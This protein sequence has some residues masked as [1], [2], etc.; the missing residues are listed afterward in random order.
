MG[1]LQFCEGLPKKKSL[2]KRRKR[3]VPL[4]GGAEREENLAETCTASKNG[5]DEAQLQ[6]DI[7]RTMYAEEAGNAALVYTSCCMPTMSRL[8]GTI[9]SF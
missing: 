1:N 2:A 5:T 6:F 8:P 3:V 9:M 4:Y 7:S